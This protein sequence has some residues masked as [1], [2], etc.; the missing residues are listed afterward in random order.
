MLFS[1][2]Q[3]Q[4]GRTL[5]GVVRS[6]V[7]GQTIEGV[8]VQAGNKYTLTDKE[9][10]FSITIDDP[11]GTLKINHIGFKEQSVAYDETTTLLDLQL[12]PTE[13][14]IEEVEVVS[15]GYQTIPKERATGSFVQIDKELLNR[16]VGTDIMQQLDGVAPGLQFDNRRGRPISNIRG[17][18]TFSESGVSPLIVVDNFPF[19]GSLESI[20]PNDV[21]SVTLLKDAAA[22]SIWGAKAGNG[23]IVINLK[24][25][26]GKGTRL[27]F[28]SNSSIQSKPDLGY[29]RPISSSD[30]LSVEKF[31]YDKGHYDRQLLP[32]TKKFYVHSPYIELLEKHKAGGVDLDDVAQQVESWSKQDYRDDLVQYHYRPA[33]YLQN[34]VAIEGGEENISYYLSAG[35]DR[36]SS[37]LEGMGNSRFTTRSVVDFRPLK[38][39]SM[40][41]S[42]LYTGAKDVNSKASTYPI[43]PGG[44]RRNLYPYASLL[45]ENGN[46][47]A[48]PMVYNLDYIDGLSGTKLQDWKFRP[49]SDWRYQQEKNNSDHLLFGVLTNYKPWKGF[50]LEVSY[51]FERQLSESGSLYEKESFFTRNLVN[52]FTQIQG[53]DLKLII[54]NADI[55]DVGSSALTGHRG[56]LL[57]AFNWTD[58]AG[59]HMLDV[60]A[61]GEVNHRGYTSRGIRVY[62]FDSEILSSAD[63][64]YVNP[65]PI[66]DR[67]ASNARIPSGQSLNGNTNRTVSTFANMG[68]TY[69]GRYGLSFSAR[70][71]A[72]N[73]FGVKSNDRWNPLWSV[74]TFWTLSGEEW[75]QQAEF[76]NSLKIRLTYGHG[77]NSTIRAAPYPLLLYSSSNAALTN[78]PFSYINYPPNPNLK[79]E[80]VATTNIGVDFALFRNRLSGTLE[81]YRKNA[82]D[83]IVEDPVDPTVGFNQTFRNVGKISTNGFDV[84]L[85]VLTLDKKVKWRQTLAISGVDTK[86]KQFTGNMLTSN[87]YV[88]SGG[89]TINPIKEKMVYPVFSYKSAGLDPQDGS[90][91]GYF[92]DEISTNYTKMLNDSLDNFN[93]HGSA[94]PRFY[95]FYRHTVEWQSFSLYGSFL[96]K[97]GYYFR[98]ET[99]R[100]N[101]LFNNWVGHA[102]FAD[103]W[104]N[105]GDELHTTIPSTPYPASENRDI[106]YANSEHNIERGDHIRIQDLGIDFSLPLS[107]SSKL[108]QLKIG[109]ACRNLGIIWSRS[110][111]GLDPDYLGMPARRQYTA[112]VRFQL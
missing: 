63:L 48:I 51:N 108:S 3:A 26:R 46:P 106:F 73:V 104:Q 30:F 87:V 6:A 74:G 68:Y 18:S 61:G 75:L 2:A 102:D 35:Y 31:L 69:L 60:L 79:W 28:T 11:K 47:E 42:L 15:T 12:H 38:T 20:N 105:P 25:G 100:Y 7:D 80:D 21:E 32:T 57:G 72:S 65:Y 88:S 17:I 98:K 62:G 99:I 16:R 109:I 93:F 77:G 67:L 103:R 89:Q 9:G 13:Q 1:D 41:A 39:V 70:K 45:D 22:A 112:V 78:Y 54:P 19:E 34:S 85:N 59:Y 94:L 8:S 84:Q 86:V 91:R 27:S 55:K 50:R 52:R 56:R 101:E 37:W 14:Q 110:G 29:Q 10:R 92:E 36:N 83:L 24:K 71:D 33:I 4:S 58:D 66:Y 107:K 111:S 95:G 82:T 64:D 76:I 90:P 53:N 96:F 97:M 49:L 40:Q 44:G 81:Y 5:G 23:V 43:N